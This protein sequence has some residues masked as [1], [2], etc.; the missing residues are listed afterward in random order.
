MQLK[1]GA[2]RPVVLSCDLVFVSVRCCSAELLWVKGFWWGV[3]KLNILF[4]SITFLCL[5]N[6]YEVLQVVLNCTV[7]IHKDCVFQV[8]EMYTTHSQRL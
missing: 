7:L 4:H 6:R 5:S 3:K 8:I 2:S 1:Y